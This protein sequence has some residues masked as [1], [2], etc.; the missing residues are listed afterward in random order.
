MRIVIIGGSGLIGTELT[1][2]LADHGHIITILTR[3]EPIAS[4]SGE[5]WKRWNGKDVEELSKLLAGTDAVINLAGVSIGSGRWT[6]EKKAAIRSSRVEC[7]QALASAIMSLEKKPEVVVQAS[8]VGFYGT[9]SEP[10]DETSQK[11]NDWL[12]AVCQ[13]WENSLDGIDDL[14]VRKVIIRSGVVLSNKGGILGQMKLPIQ[15]FFGGPIGSGDQWISWIH[16]KDEVRAI[17]YLIETTTARGIYNLSSPD[18]ITNR[19]F[20][21]ILAKQLHR[22]FWIRVPAFVL[23]LMLGEMSTLVLD[24]QR[25]FPNRLSEANFG[26]NFPGLEEALK[27]LLV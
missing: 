10:V 13:D 23:K 4:K 11:G 21:R 3:K 16:I 22:P 6:K 19:N 24:G 9:G 20:G 25:V 12:A 26:F 18:P 7:G 15:L 5:N 17:R 8:A 27:D 2:E 1:R 14:M